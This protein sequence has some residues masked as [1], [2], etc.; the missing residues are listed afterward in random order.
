MAAALLQ[1]GQRIA[2]L[3]D[4]ARLNVLAVREAIHFAGLAAEALIE[5]AASVVR[6]T[7]QEQERVAA[8]ATFERWSGETGADAHWIEAEGR[9]AAIIGERGSRADL[10]V[11]GQPREDDRLARQS[12]SA[13]LF[14][15]DRPVLLVPS[16]SPASFGRRVAIA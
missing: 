6:S 15:T 11:S 3:M 14:G 4:G 2:T 9:A 16:E 8:R 1:A 7:A 10:I 12:F 5:E 13:A